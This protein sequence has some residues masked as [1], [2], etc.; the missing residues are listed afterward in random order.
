MVSSK[1]I[2]IPVKAVASLWWISEDAT[3]HIISYAIRT[4]AYQGTWRGP[5][6]AAADALDILSGL[7][8]SVGP[9]SRCARSSY[10]LVSDAVVRTMVRR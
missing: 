8:A 7:T 1:L 4:T 2:M 10:D 3:T 5:A 9:Q 6:A